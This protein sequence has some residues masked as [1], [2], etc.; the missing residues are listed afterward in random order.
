MGASCSGLFSKCSED[1]IQRVDSNRV[2][3]AMHMQ[4]LSE[5]KNPQSNF[6]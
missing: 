3:Q 2:K 5:A 6:K 1:P 4:E